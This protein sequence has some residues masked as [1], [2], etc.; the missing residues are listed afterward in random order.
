MIEGH[1]E[2]PGPEPIRRRVLRRA[3][4]G[5]VGW[6]EKRWGSA[7][8]RCRH[9]RIP[10]EESGVQTCCPRAPGHRR[11]G[12]PPPEPPPQGIVSR[13]AART[14]VRKCVPTGISSSTAPPEH[15]TTARQPCLGAHCS[16]PCPAV[17]PRP[18]RPHRRNGD[19]CGPP[20]EPG[21]QR[22]W[23]PRCS[24]PT[25]SAG[26]QGPSL[27]LDVAQEH[28]VKTARQESSTNLH[29]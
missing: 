12:L 17:P 13:S 20:A 10:A 29:R 11:E 19:P 18:Q 23:I 8:R 5:G 25:L 15:S 14:R 16:P 7:P 4:H 9:P 3:K 28:P 26:H 21:P 27:P 1:C 22:R 2:F 24:F 6:S